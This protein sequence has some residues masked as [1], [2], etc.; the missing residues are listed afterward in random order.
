LACSSIASTHD[1]LIV[2]IGHIGHNSQ[3]PQFIVNYLKPI[4]SD[5]LWQGSGNGEHGHGRHKGLAAAVQPD[6]VRDTQHH[7]E[8]K[9]NSLLQSRDVDHVQS[10][11]QHHVN[12]VVELV[13]EG[14]QNA[15]ATL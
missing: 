9:H 15:P 6:P 10:E 5:L 12:F 11:I 3:N 8:F 7:Q 14:A 13:S 2:L 4:Q 1:K